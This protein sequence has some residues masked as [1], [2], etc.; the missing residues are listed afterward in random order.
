VE[1]GC[2]VFGFP[3]RLSICSTPERFALPSLLNQSLA[4]DPP[5][6]RCPLRVWQLDP[7]TA[8][9]LGSENDFSCP[10][11]EIESVLLP[12]CMLESLPHEVFWVLFQAGS[13]NV[14]RY[15]SID[16]AL[17]EVNSPAPDPEGESNVNIYWVDAK[18][19]EDFRP[20][21]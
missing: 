4:L 2:S 15:S 6:T 11:T 19:I 14:C 20:K 3:F 17:I 21:K 1:D 8:T 18:I 9:I 10:F 7:P 12:D 13:D 16:Y 5:T